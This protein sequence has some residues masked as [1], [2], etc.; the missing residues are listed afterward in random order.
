V[1]RLIAAV[2]L[3]LGLAAP[4]AVWSEPSAADNKVTRGY[5]L[6]LDLVKRYAVSVRALKAAEAH[7]PALKAEATAS[8][9][10]PEAPVAAIAARLKRHP[11]IY[12]FFQANGLSETDAT[13]IGVVLIQ[14]AFASGEKDLSAFPGVSPQQVAFMRQHEAQLKPMLAGLFVAD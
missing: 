10:E 2:A 12:A 6:T 11:K 5:V 13:L 9:N 14:A 4:L 3:V 8:E 1:K 7:D